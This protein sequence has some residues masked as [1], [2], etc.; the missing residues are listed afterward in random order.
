MG[1]KSKHVEE[2]ARN[3]LQQ[4]HEIRNI[5]VEGTKNGIWF[6]ETEI[7]SLSGG[8][9]VKKIKIDGKTGNIISVE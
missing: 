6:V 1:I 2:I 8:G 5:K 7:H 4:H 9:G 3:F